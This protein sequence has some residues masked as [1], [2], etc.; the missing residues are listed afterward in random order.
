[1]P[2]QDV[3]DEIFTTR[4]M[5]W[6]LRC[7]EST[8]RNYRKAGMPYIQGP[9]PLYEWPAVVAWLKSTASGGREETHGG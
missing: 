5:T 7:S 8:L 9:R 4:E 2:L 6:R 1:M 3:S